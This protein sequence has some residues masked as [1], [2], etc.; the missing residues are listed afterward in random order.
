[1][2]IKDDTKRKRNRKLRKH[3]LTS[4]KSG[5]RWH[6]TE[7]N[8]FAFSAAMQ[9]PCDDWTVVVTNPLK[10]YKKGVPIAE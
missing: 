6:G 2:R 7:V 8:A 4:S 9:E 1:M 5:L 10:G 3:V